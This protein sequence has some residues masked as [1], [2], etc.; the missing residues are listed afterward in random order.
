MFLFGKTRFR[1]LFYTQKRFVFNSILGQNSKL[2][3][4]CEKFSIDLN[5]LFFKS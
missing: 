2:F 5:I 3:Q 4:Y 1:S